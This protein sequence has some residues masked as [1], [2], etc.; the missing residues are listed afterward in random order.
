MRAFAK[1]SEDRFADRVVNFFQA[2]FPDARVEHRGM[3]RN[4]VVGQAARA[5]E[6][7]FRTEIE[8]VTYVMTGWVLG[9]DFDKD[10]PAV[11]AALASETM[12]AGDK[13]AWLADFTKKLF[14]T[15]GET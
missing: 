15:L 7:G 14:R 10:F 6:Y 4:F 12:A 3:L 11:R 2:Q 5:R 13:A 1:A 8:L 9:G